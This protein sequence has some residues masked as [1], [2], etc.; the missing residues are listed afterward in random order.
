[1]TAPSQA[2][3]EA[4]SSISRNDL[5][6]VTFFFGSSCSVLSFIVLSISCLLTRS[7]FGILFKSTFPWH[8]GNFLASVPFLHVPIAGTPTNF[9]PVDFRRE[10]V[11]E[12][13]SLI[14][15]TWSVNGDQQRLKYYSSILDH[16][17]IEI[18]HSKILIDWYL[19]EDGHVAAQWNVLG[20]SRHNKG[21]FFTIAIL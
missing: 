16:A 7:H 14:Q 13:S 17:G 15:F 2:I 10:L 6:E 9:P 1:M 3:S 21:G 11:C 19:A 20:L 12:T 18:S 5:L 4:P 8:T